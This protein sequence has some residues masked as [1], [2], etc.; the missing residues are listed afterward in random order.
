M[1][2]VIEMARSVGATAYTNRHYPD[3]PTHTF[4][5]D[6]LERFAELV[7][8]DERVKLA[9]PQPKNRP[10]ESDYTSQ[11]A[12]TSALEA[13]CDGLAEQPAPVQGWKPSEADYK[14]WWD[15]HGLHGPTARAAF[16]DAA[17]LYLTAAPQPAQ[18]KPLTDMQVDGEWILVRDLDTND[19]EKSRL[20]ARA[21]EAAH[22]IKE[23]T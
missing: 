23:N 22:N 16:E 12:Y 7:R 11:V 1:K 9:V 3:R 8:A 5:V 14:E 10:V 19:V 6:Q 4:N 13:Y 17:S 21:I 2:T 15:R 18:Q 20:F